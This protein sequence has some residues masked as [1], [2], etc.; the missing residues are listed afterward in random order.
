MLKTRAFVAY[1][2]DPNAIMCKEGVKLFFFLCS[3]LLIERINH[4]SVR[5]FYMVFHRNMT[6]QLVNLIWVPNVAIIRLEITT[7]YFT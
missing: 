6:N 7:L 4:I 5:D 3:M 2:N 1:L